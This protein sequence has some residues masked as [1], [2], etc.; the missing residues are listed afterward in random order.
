M[1]NKTDLI[2]RAKSYVAANPVKF[3]VFMETYG[4]A[5][6][7]DFVVDEWEDDGRLLEWEEVEQLINSLTS[8][9]N[10]PRN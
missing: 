1:Q 10:E 3:H 4:N 8:V 5:E 2:E 7:G 9:W 6:W